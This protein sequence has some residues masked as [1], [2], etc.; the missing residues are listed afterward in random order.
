MKIL[1]SI[2]A[3]VVGFL[4]SCVVIMAIETINAIVYLPPDT[5]LL[6]H[7]NKL[8][9]D[10][11]AMKEWIDSIPEIAMV[12][13]LLAWQLGSFF[14][15]GVSALIAGRARLLHAGI[16]GALVLAGTI[17]NMYQLKVECGYSLPDYG[18]ILG[19]VL[20]VPVSLI[21][22][23]LVSVMFPPAAPPP[24]GAV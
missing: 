9:E 14:G 22:G 19:L 5:T 4:V 16:V 23:K 3:V 17:Q 15:G 21:G 18:I 7:M 8:T 12:V 10:K 2:A 11:Q 13:V 20:P 6:D 1:R 24:D